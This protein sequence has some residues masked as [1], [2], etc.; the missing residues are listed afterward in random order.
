[1]TGTT[2]QADMNGKLGPGRMVLVVGPSGAGKDTL[3]NA[4]RDRLS[5]DD[6]V[7]FAIRRITR[8]ADGATETHVPISEGG[9]DEAV[10]A[11][12]FALAW[13]AHGLGY[14]LP[15]DLDDVIRTGGTVIANGSRHALADALEK[16][17]NL[18]IL[19]I[20]APKAVLAERLAARG[21]ESREEIERRLDRSTFDMPE[22][23]NVAR[24]ENTGTVEEALDAILKKI[25]P[26]T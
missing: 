6:R 18:L 17:E 24:I 10:A 4:L 26:G 22:V 25:G 13:R 14:I 5:G 20:T 15:A 23:A 7:R 16:Y 12:R 1:M 11:G 2:M 19:L 21:R 3:L 9:Y 8:P